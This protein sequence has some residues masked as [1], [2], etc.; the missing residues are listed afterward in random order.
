MQK[1][2]FPILEYDNTLKAVIEPTENHK[3]IDIPEHCVVCFFQEVID[4]LVDDEQ[5]VA[6]Y[7][8]KSELG[9]RQVYRVTENGQSFALFHPGVGAPLAAAL[10]EEVIAIGASKFIACG[11]AGVLDKR[12]CVGHVLVPQLAVR[13]EG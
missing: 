5:A 9:L 1:R 4:K 6:I 3:P 11:G 10:L 2:D 8:I 7:R 13:D 12:I